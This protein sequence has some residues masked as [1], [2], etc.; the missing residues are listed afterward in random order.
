MIRRPPRSTLFPYTTLFRSERREHLPLGA[1]ARVGVRRQ[2]PTNLQGSIGIIARLA[3]AE[4][5]VPG[6][7]VLSLCPRGGASC[8]SAIG[9]RILHVGRTGWGTGGVA[10]V[11][12]VCRRLGGVRAQPHQQRPGSV[13]ASGRRSVRPQVAVGRS[14]FRLAFGFFGTT[15]QRGCGPQVSVWAVQL[16]ARS[17]LEIL[18]KWGVGCLCHSGL[19]QEGAEGFVWLCLLAIRPQMERIPL[20]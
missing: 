14:I 15:V 5:P 10:K 18:R 2:L 7:T 17:E 3:T 4:C 9:S 6:W 20:S 12:V 11:G 19:C 13:P 8:G 1:T 16:A